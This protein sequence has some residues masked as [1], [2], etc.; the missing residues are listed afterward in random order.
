MCGARGAPRP[1]ITASGMR[2]SSAVLERGRAAPEP[3]ALRLALRDRQLRGAREPDRGGDVLGAGPAPAILRAA[4]QQRLERRAAADEHR[5][6]AL[7]RADLVARDREQVE[8]HVS[9]VDRRPCRTPARRRCG[10]AR[11]APSRARASSGTA[12]IVP[13]SLFTHMTVHDGDVVVDQRRRAPSRSTTPSASRRRMRS[14]PPSRAAWCTA[15][16]TALC[17]IGVVTTALRPCRALR[18]PGAEDGEVVGL[19]AAGGEADLVRAARRDTAR[20]AR[21]PRRARRGPRAPSG[22]RWRGCRSAGRRTAPWPRDLAAH[23][24]RRGVVEIDGLWHK[25][26]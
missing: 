18:A 20:R 6:D 17:S 14:S 13:I 22:A 25:S 7:G 15:A 1:W 3:R 10:T 24:G 26:I 19:G 16:S 21:A 12:W 9:R 23:R 4:V 2:A 8:R 11:R 5:A